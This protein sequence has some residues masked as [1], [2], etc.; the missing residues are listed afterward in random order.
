MRKWQEYRD[1]AMNIAAP[2]VKQAG[3]YVGAAADE[4]NRR[5]RKN[6]RKIK[7]NL[8]MIKFRR[9]LNTVCGL[10]III[11][12]SLAIIKIILSFLKDYED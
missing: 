12:T 4:V 8:H 5:Y 6:K 2:Y 1:E 10:M 7:R 11:T 3:E 9:A